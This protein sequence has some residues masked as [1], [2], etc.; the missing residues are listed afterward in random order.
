[1]AEEGQTA[2]AIDFG[3][4]VKIIG[5]ALQAGKHDHHIVP[6]AV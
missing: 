4:L 1:M 2:G 5:Y 6:H 3:G